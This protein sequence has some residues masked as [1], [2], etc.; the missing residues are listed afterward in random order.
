[1]PSDLHYYPDASPVVCWAVA[2]FAALFGAAFLAQ[3]FDR[4]WHRPAEGG[5]QVLLGA[6]ILWMAWRTGRYPARPAL[7]LTC[8][9]LVLRPFWRPPSRLRFAEVGSFGLYR[10]HN[11]ARLRTGSHAGRLLGWTVTS[12]HLVASLKGG[13]TRTI[14]LPGFSNARLLAELE[15]R[16]GLPIERLPDRK[17]G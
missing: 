9:A 13:G 14:T 1:M 10:Q 16:S 15:A 11:Q 3:G 17:A 12:E 4:I 5:G 7:S 2:G 8:G 6:A